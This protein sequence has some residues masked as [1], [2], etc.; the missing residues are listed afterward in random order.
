ML[1]KIPTLHY[2]NHE[3]KEGVCESVLAHKLVED[4]PCGDATTKLIWEAI[5]L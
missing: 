1:K 3:E 5:P 2:K 4:D